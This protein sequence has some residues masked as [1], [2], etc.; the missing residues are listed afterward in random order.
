MATQQEKAERL[1]SLHDAGCFVLPNAWDFA[2]A[3]LTLDAG[4]DVLATTS[5]GVAFAQGFID[6][7]AIGRERMIDLSGRLAARFD[8]PV[9]ADLEAGYGPNPAD[10]GET[11]VLA[12]AAGI[13]GCNIEDGLGGGLRERDASVQ[14]IAAAAQA[15]RDAGLPAFSINARTDPYIRRIGTPERCFEEAVARG[16]AYLAAGARSVFVPGV[17]DIPTIGALVREIGGPINVMAVGGGLT[18]PIEDLAAA[19]VRRISLG[20]AVMSAAYGAAREAIA[21]VRDHGDFDFPPGVAFADF[22]KLMSRDG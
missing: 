2:S 9:T 4:Y 17:V 16:R 21:R 18:P 8:V 10:V 3:V 12:I 19:G 15:A 20:G 14:R 5:A 22:M 6:G 13:V 11:I 1:A 7:E